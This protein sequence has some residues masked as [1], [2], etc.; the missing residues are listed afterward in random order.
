MSLSQSPEEQTNTE[1]GSRN[2]P[3]ADE[4]LATEVSQAPVESKEDGNKDDEANDLSSLA[5]NDEDKELERDNDPT[6]TDPN[7][8]Y[9]YSSSSTSLPGSRGSFGETEYGEGE[10]EDF[11]DDE[12]FDDEDKSFI[13]D[14]RG[15][16]RGMRSARTSISSLPGSVVVYPTGKVQSNGQ[17]QRGDYRQNI[18]AHDR[19]SMI[20]GNFGGNRVRSKKN[21]AKDRRS[22]NYAPQVR[23]MDSP[24]RHPSSVRAMQMGDEDYYDDGGMDDGNYFSSPASRNGRMNG[25]HNG[26]PRMSDMSFRSRPMS[27]SDQRSYHAKSPQASQQTQEYALVLLHCTLLPPSFPLSLPAGSPPPSKEQLREILPEPYWR[28]WKLLEEKIGATGILRDRGILISH[29]QEAYDLLEERLLETLELTR[30]RLAY[31][32]FIGGGD[33]T[34]GEE[35]GSDADENDT[36][37]GGRVKEKCQDC[38]QRVINNLESIEKKWEVRVYAANGLMGQGAWAAAWKEMEKVDVEVGVCLPTKLRNELEQRLVQEETLRLQRLAEEEKKTKESQAENKM[39]E[40]HPNPAQWKVDGLDDSSRTIP[41]REQAPRKPSVRKR[42][43]PAPGLAP[44]QY[45]ADDIN[46]L[47]A[48][49]NYIRMVCQ[50]NQLPIVTVLLVLL[51][52]VTPSPYSLFGRSSDTATQIDPFVSAQPSIIS[53][54]SF[55]AAFM[56]HSSIYPSEATQSSLTTIQQSST[57]SCHQPHSLETA[58]T[59]LRPS[60]SSAYQKPQ[61]D[62]NV[63]TQLEPTPSHRDRETETTASTQ[64]EPATSFRESYLDTTTPMQLESSASLAPSA[65]SNSPLS[66]VSLAPPASPD[67]SDSSGSVASSTPSA[68]P[69]NNREER[70]VEVPECLPASTSQAHATIS[71]EPIVMEAESEREGLLE[72]ASPPPSASRSINPIVMAADKWVESP[73][74]QPSKEEDTQAIEPDAITSTHQ[75][76]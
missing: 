71:V 6:E 69:P 54:P 33:E 55:Q 7:A 51:A 41:T 22:Y 15:G 76:T 43:R 70:P 23:D 9:R 63:S 25:H 19:N 8:E 30:P 67:S 75:D 49:F 53:E 21:I 42:E 45:P 48:L 34:D 24:F 5:P 50:G 28:R 74:E 68:M 3:P 37:E 40:G 13:S 58:S 66:I 38:G 62:E 64:S 46:L 1:A 47:K 14:L 72:S 4:A 31:G 57:V 44:T 11:P 35:H 32:H 16:V 56:S 26:S 20:D 12:H 73:S 10:I 29:P 17:F 18:N 52:L 27:P 65:P 36:D 2:D 61:P 60:S 39:P 59:Q